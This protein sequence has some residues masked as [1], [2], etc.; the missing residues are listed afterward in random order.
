MA[1]FE[2][3]IL[4]KPM[5]P[6]PN[7]ITP[8]FEHPQ[9]EAALA[10]IVLAISLATT[11]LFAWFRLLC[12]TF[13]V[14]QLHVEDYFIPVAWLAAVGHVACG[15]VIN[16]FAPI[17]HS[18]EMTMRIF[19]KYLL[20]YK[21]GSIFY[22][23]SI[24]LIKISML[25]QV[26]RVFVPRG[27]QSKTY[28]VCHAL[29]WVNV[30]Y[31]AITVFTMMFTCRPIQ[32]SWQPWVPGTCMNIG[33]I[34]MSTAAVNLVGDLCI[35]AVT[36]VKIWKL[37]RVERRQRIKLSVVFFAA[38]I[39]CAFA[40][41]CLWYNTLSLQGHDF[42][43]TS[44]YMTIACHGEIASGMFVL[45]LPMLPRFFTHVK[46]NT[47]LFSTSRTNL[48]RR[49]KKQSQSTEVEFSDV[50]G[51]RLQRDY[52]AAQA[53]DAGRVGRKKSLW[54]ISY[55]ESDRNSSEDQ[56]PIFPTSSKNDAKNGI[57][58]QTEVSVN[59]R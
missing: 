31:Y 17:I 32:K 26:L 28:Y 2:M 15:F 9:D 25:I 16:E 38:I 21:L 39:P 45:F 37:M 7:H 57:F 35:L 56:R 41:M 52:E 33:A 58:V 30:I 40:I 24:V 8:D 43:H 46:E 59:S 10:Y 18:W 47:T 11:T 44:A 42:A 12:K 36:Q 14:G 13:I 55:S 22:N 54:H 23:I 50:T 3:S 19:G 53:A 51:S 34:S 4:D 29:I 6:A 5:A 20:W 1:P 48:N 49:S 27:S